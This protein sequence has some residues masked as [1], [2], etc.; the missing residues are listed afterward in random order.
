M[1]LSE[2]KKVL[3]TAETVDFKLENGTFVPEHFHVT[4]VGVITKHFIDCG[5]TERKEKVA[6]F[7]LWDANDYEHRLKPGKLQKIIALSEKV[8]EMEDLEIEVEYQSETIG[9]YDLGFDGKSFILLSK[10][11]ACLAKENCGV[12][13]PKHH[14]SDLETPC[15][16]PDGNCC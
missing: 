9:K 11:T 8:L 6:N 10:A 12:P 2:I 5:G 13:Q 7:Q 16:A 4:E 1:K 3:E 14:L 15:C